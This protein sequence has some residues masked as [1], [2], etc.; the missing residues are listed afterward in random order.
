MN[1]PLHKET[2][3]H[4]RIT[5]HC[6]IQTEANEHF[7][8]AYPLVDAIL[9]ETLGNGKPEHIDAEAWIC[10]TMYIRDL[11]TYALDYVRD[12]L[13]PAPQ[14]SMP[15]LGGLYGNKET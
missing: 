5:R 7:A 8:R 3:A 11:M 12:H 15:Q 6:I 1:M 9:L 13:T 14:Q 10:A 4:R 2:K